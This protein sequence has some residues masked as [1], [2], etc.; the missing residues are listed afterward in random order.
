MKRI[1]VSQIK[2]NSN[3]FILHEKNWELSLV[4]DGK[5]YTVNISQE[6]PFNIQLTDILARFSINLYSSFFYMNDY[7]S[8][9]YKGHHWDLWYREKNYPYVYQLDAEEIARIRLL[10]I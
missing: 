4:L 5:V 2:Q 6:D 1:S 10:L 3:G 9:H 7:G 8:W